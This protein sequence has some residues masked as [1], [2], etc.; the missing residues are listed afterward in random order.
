M[1]KKIDITPEPRTLEVLGDVPLEPWQCIAEL[2]DNCLDEFSIMAGVEPRVD[3][4]L[5]K[6]TSDEPPKLVVKDNGRGMD[7]LELEH[8][9]RAGYTSKARHGTLG[10]FGMGFNIATARLGNVSTVITTKRGLGVRLK[11]VI[12]FRKLQRENTYWTDVE[13]IECS[14]E[15]HGTEV[16]VHLNR[17]VGRQLFRKATQ[18]GIREKLGEVYSFMLRQK[19]PGLPDAL[20]SGFPLSNRISANIYFD[21]RPI[22]AVLPCI[23]S[24][25]RTVTVRGQ[26]ISAVQLVDEQLTDAWICLDCG[27]WHRKEAKSCDECDSQNIEA[28]ERAVRGWLGVQRFLDTSNY[29]IDFVRNGRKI[30]IKDKSIFKW[31]DPDTLIEDIEY[32]IEM[33][34]NRGRLVGEIHLDHINVTYQKNDFDKT[35]RD[36]DAAVQIVRGDQ[37]LKMRRASS[38]NNSPLATLFSAFRR[39]D[40]GLKCLVTGD[41]KKATHHVAAT[42]GS[43]FYQNLP[44]FK[45]DQKWYDSAKEHDR[46]KNEADTGKGK[47]SG[48]T[49]VSPGEKLLGPGGGT[50]PNNPSP[51]D[52]KPKAL[53]SAEK[54][55][56]YKAL[57]SRKEELCGTL[58]LEGFAD[59]N[60]EIYTTRELIEVDGKRVPAFVLDKA[61]NSMEVFVD[62]R[63][64]ILIEYG[65]DYKDVAI[66]EIAHRVK[67]FSSAK[68]PIAAIFSKVLENYKDERV[69]VES[70]I[71]RIEIFTKKLTDQCQ[72]RLEAPEEFWDWLEPEEKAL[73]EKSAVSSSVSVTL[74]WDQATKDGSFLNW[75]N[76]DVVAGMLERRPEQF[77]DGSVFRQ[78]W[79]AWGDDSAKQAILNDVLAALKYLS[80]FEENP[81]KSMRKI[82]V[83]NTYLDELEDSFVED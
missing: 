3:I 19:V 6:E 48:S 14:K 12:D 17:E 22:E 47:G 29:G 32:P 71:S 76:L 23:W 42:W 9:I 41:G 80:A 62:E 15:E 50:A 33:P 13:Q 26:E 10:L 74:N 21:G 53:S 66:M 54:A 34:A 65:R 82:V 49:D 45:D 64:P 58:L 30:L 40:P 83:A 37:P 61:G 43:R 11:T 16:Q 1:K 8:S 35:G 73:C 36:W 2:T 55:E 46:L 51:Q 70:L 28:R 24:H 75:A 18:D 31:R 67:S 57:G 4:E 27:N 25:D 63:H 44:E 7:D 69:S 5:I 79:E 81:Q 60:V 72:L 38:P 56:R 59:W 68:E 20:E 78:A 52:D 77:F 39:N